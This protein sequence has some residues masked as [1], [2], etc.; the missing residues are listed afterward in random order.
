MTRRSVVRGT[1]QEVMD[2]RAA[3]K[4]GLIASAVFLVALLVGYPIA[5]GG[6][7]W[8]VLRFIAAIVL[9]EG[10][11][12]PPNAFSLAAL[13]VGVLVHFVLAVVYT[14]IL[15]FIVHRWRMLISIVGGALFGVAIYLINFFTFTLFFP[16]FF[17]A[18][19]WPFMIGHILFGAI[20]GG[21]YEL[22]E[23]DKFVPYEET[24]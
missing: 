13:I 15:A 18:R 12:T 16:W 11:L 9:G 21:V 6:T 23:E 14:G 2:W 19:A 24:P 5:T 3:V 1:M 10:I 8:V 20:A 17:P 22:L 7:P 4:A